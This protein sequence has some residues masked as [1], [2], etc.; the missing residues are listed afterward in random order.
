MATEPKLV[1]YPPKKHLDDKFLELSKKASS[2]TISGRLSRMGFRFVYMAQVLPLKPGTVVAGRAYTL[3]YIPRWDDFSTWPLG[4]ERHKY[5]EHVAIESVGPGDVLVIDARGNINAGVF[6]DRLVTRMQYRGAA[7]L[8]T[9]GAIRDVPFMKDMDFPIF[10]RAPHGYYHLQE[11]WAMDVQLPISCGNVAV[12]PGD[13]VV[14]DDDG[15]VIVPQAIAEDVIKESIAQEEIET[16]TRELFEKGYS[17]NDLHGTLPPDL[18]AEY[19]RWRQ[20]R[21]LS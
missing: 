18:Q 21:G 13:L 12:F 9:D 8:V 3:R 5:P 10:V 20:A 1:L 4:E 17:V 15:V 16:F 2:A 19:D 7:G 14:G 6:G 11:H